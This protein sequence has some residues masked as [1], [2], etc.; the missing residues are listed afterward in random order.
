MNKGFIQLIFI[1]AL[2]L[3]IVSMM[4]VSLKDVFGNQLVKGNFSYVYNFSNWLWENYLHDPVR[5]AFRVWVDVLW[6]PFVSAMDHI[7]KGQ[8]PAPFTQ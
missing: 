7:G 4:G 3:I 8:T 2:L 6:K 1:F 5:I